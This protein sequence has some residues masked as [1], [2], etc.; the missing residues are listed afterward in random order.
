MKNTG[1]TMESPVCKTDTKFSFNW[2]MFIYSVI[3]LYIGY[4]VAHIEW[5][6]KQR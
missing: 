6:K 2:E 1:K 3:V 4:R 5:L